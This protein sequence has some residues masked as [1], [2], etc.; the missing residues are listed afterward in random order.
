MKKSTKRIPFSAMAVIFLL[1]ACVPAQPTVDPNEVANQVATSVALTVAAQNTQTAAAR[2]TDT[3]I[4]SPTLVPTQVLFDTPI[5][6]TATPFVVVPPT[7]VS[8]GGGGSTT[9]KPDYDC[10]I[11]RRRPFDNTFFRPGD[12]FDIRW[13]IV[14][15]GTRNLRVG[16]DVKYSIGSQMTGV[17]FVELPEMKPGDQYEIILDAVAPATEGNHIMTWVVEGQLCYPYAAIIVEK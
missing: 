12:T 13:T 8:G 7:A 5:V 14:N 1:A 17:T 15:T 3:L 10:D 16:T 6:P 2:P 11:I 9:T 4:P